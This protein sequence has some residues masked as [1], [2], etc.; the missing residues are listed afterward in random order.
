MNRYQEREDATRQTKDP[1][2]AAASIRLT[3][4]W[5]FS[6]EIFRSVQ[7]GGLYRIDESGSVSE[8]KTRSASQTPIAWSIAKDRFYFGDSIANVIYV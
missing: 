3:E 6:V 7:A 2:Q 8:G 4:P 5:H 1:L